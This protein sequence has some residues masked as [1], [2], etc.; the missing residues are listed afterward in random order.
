[1]EGE[2]KQKHQDALSDGRKEE[3]EAKRGTREGREEEVGMPSPRTSFDSHQASAIL[4]AL[5]KEQMVPTMRNPS[6]I[7]PKI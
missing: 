4:A 6:T 5:E 3:A 7:T 1:M 2:K